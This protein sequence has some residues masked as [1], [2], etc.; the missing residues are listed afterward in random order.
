MNTVREQ[1]AASQAEVNAICEQIIGCA[2]RVSNTL[3]CGFLEKVYENALGMELRKADLR[4]EQQKP[5]RVLYDGAVVGE[6][7]CDLVIEDCVIVELKAAGALDDSHLAQC[8][9][10]LKATGIRVGLLLNFGKP[11]VEIRRVVL[12]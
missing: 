12:D 6:F 11:R 3:G 5:L 7:S 9:N 2:F 8:L 1:R 10:Y 4:V